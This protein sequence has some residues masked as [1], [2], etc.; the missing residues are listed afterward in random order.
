MELNELGLSE[1]EGIP[2]YERY[3][4]ALNKFLEEKEN[5]DEI[6][7]IMLTGSFA[8]GE[9]NRESDIDLILVNSCNQEPEDR[10]AFFDDIEVN[11]VYTG[12]EELK[13]KMQEEKKSNKRIFA[14]VVHA[15]ISLYGKN[16]EL[17]KLADEVYNAPVPCID[18]IEKN[19]TINFL[20]DQKKE[21]RKLLANGELINFHLRLNHVIQ[22]CVKNYF[23]IKKM[24][25]PPWKRISE[26]IRDNDFKE[27]LFNALNETKNSKKL[28]KT[29]KLVDKVTE[30]MG[31]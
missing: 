27:L 8:R 11:Y 17:K 5:S 16:E 19:N 26:S 23:I 13:R 2:L 1:F 30:L 25:W 24:L 6:M 31:N 21:L 12:A 22:N 18:G 9:I 14:T 20:N 3:L 4:K 10:K 15:G 29:N 28:E 7:G